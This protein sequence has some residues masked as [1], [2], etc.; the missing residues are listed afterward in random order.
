MLVEERRRGVAGYVV[1]RCVGRSERGVEKTNRFRTP[2]FVCALFGSC[3]SDVSR[4]ASPPSVTA[5]SLGQAR[6]TRRGYPT[7]SSYPTRRK[8]QTSS[9]HTPL[10]SAPEAWAYIYS[11][12]D[13][14]TKKHNKFTMSAGKVLIILSDANK[15]AVR[16]QDGS[17]SQED[18]GV[19][20][21]ELATPLGQLLDAGYE[22]VVRILLNV[23]HYEPLTC[24]FTVRFARREISQRRPALRVTP[25]LLR[26]LVDEAKGP[27]AYQA[28]GDGEQH[29]QPSPIRLHL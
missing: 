5:S 20:L 17:V 3:S 22:V 13:Y 9:L 7:S 27:G 4:V 25:R 26:E 8:A 18:T 1:G 15:L 23:S 19:F 24:Q 28:N 11:C 6:G 12:T 16:K 14:L 2:A 29:P 21:T 10:L